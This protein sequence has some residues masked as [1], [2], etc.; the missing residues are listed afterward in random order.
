MKKIPLCILTCFLVIS[1]F[2]CTNYS[3]TRRVDALYT[4][5]NEMQTSI[6][7]LDKEV[8]RLNERLLAIQ[9]PPTADLATLQKRIEEVNDQYRILATEIAKLQEKAGMKPIDTA[10]PKSK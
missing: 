5:V 1:T 6:I 10:P 3:T 2:S 9:G 8:K 4:K 7:A